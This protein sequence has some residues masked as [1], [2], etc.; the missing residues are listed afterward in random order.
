MLE[1]GV[2]Y[3]L[4]TFASL[5]V[6]LYKLTLCWGVGYGLVADVWVSLTYINKRLQ[7]KPSPQWTINWVIVYTNHV[8]VEGL[9][10]KRLFIYD[11]LP[12]NHLLR[13]TRSVIYSISVVLKASNFVTM[14]CSILMLEDKMTIFNMIAVYRQPCCGSNCGKCA[15]PVG[16]RFRTY[17]IKWSKSQREER[18]LSIVHW[19]QLLLCI[20]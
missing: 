7:I 17:Y 11:T 14:N 20:L 9:S 18:K 8:P 5:A 10:L 3:E 13:S 2:Y 19:F 6:S 4:T 16:K 15:L 1:L 12:Y